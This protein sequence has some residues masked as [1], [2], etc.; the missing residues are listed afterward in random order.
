MVYI[1][2]LRKSLTWT[3]QILTNDWKR[4][5]IGQVIKRQRDTGLL[6]ICQNQIETITMKSKHDFD[7]LKAMTWGGKNPVHFCNDVT[8]KVVDMMF[9]LFATMSKC[10]S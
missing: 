5:V 4:K 6:V 3:S 7:P 9:T 8:S 10:A 2:N 1:Y